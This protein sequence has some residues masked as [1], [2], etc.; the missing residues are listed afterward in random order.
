M[1][2]GEGGWVGNLIPPL[3]I[4]VN[5]SEK[6][7]YTTLYTSTMETF[8]NLKVSLANKNPISAAPYS[9]HFLPCLE[10]LN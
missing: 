5:V 10:L 8:P 7:I 3:K 1:E 6:L 2:K 4:D 9:L